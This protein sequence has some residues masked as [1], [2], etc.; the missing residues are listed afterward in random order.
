MTKH[1]VTHKFDEK[2]KLVLPNTRHLGKL[3]GDRYDRLT[4][5]ARDRNWSFTRD[6]EICE[7]TSKL[8]QAVKLISDIHAMNGASVEVMTIT[9]DYL[10]GYYTTHKEDEG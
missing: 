2:G 6:I 5:A 3:L 9:N 7:L 1:T 4:Q 10:A 8:N